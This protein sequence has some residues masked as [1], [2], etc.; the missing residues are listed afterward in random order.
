MF[1]KGFSQRTR[2]VAGILG[3]SALAAMGPVTASAASAQDL[4]AQ[5][6]ANPRITLATVHVDPRGAGDGADARSNIVD[7]SHG[8]PAK[9]SHYGNAPGGTVNLS[10]VMLQSML[11]HAGSF[12]FSVSEI[13]GGS[14][15]PTSRHYAGVAFDTNVINGRSIRRQGQ[16]R[17]VNAFM[18]GCRADGATEVL[19]EGTNV[20]CAW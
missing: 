6:L 2:L 13:A 17:D 10:P 19:F 14:H 9:R 16:S 3:A 4:A 15:S 8:L 12:T 7:T 5:I 20:H 18:N 1:R 11:N